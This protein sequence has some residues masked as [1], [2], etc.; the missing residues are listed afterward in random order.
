[1]THDAPHAA[2]PESIG[3]LALNVVRKQVDA[4]APESRPAAEIGGR[5]APLLGN[6]IECLFAVSRHRHSILIS[7]GSPA[8]GPSLSGSG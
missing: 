5:C 4:F 2:G 7:E 6:L 3:D 8:N 1:M